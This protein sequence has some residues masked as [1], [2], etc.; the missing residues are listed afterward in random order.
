M[1]S[2]FLALQRHTGLKV[3][4]LHLQPLQREVTFSGFAFVGDEYGHDE[5]DEEAT[6]HRDADNGGQAER[7]VWG[8]VYH[9][10]GILHATHPCLWT[11][12]REGR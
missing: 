8:D 4:H 7:A 5:D 10:R 2:T 11:Q 6:S 12:R 3:V 9:P 1:L